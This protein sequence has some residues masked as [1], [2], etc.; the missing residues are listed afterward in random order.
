MFSWKHIVFVEAFLG[1]AKQQS[2]PNNKSN[3]H[4]LAANKRKV[5]ARSQGRKSVQNHTFAKILFRTRSNIPFSRICILETKEQFNPNNT[6]KTYTNWR[7]TNARST[8]ENE[9]RYPNW[10]M[11]TKM[12]LTVNEEKVS[13]KWWPNRLRI[14]FPAWGLSEW[15]LCP[16]NIPVQ[17]SRRRV[18]PRKQGSE[19]RS[20][21]K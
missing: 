4:K 17:R 6:S 19:L 13:N 7:L 20:W 14:T 18:L 8:Q 5:N 16:S 12:F 10:N 2:N 1:E 15:E 11:K 9:I 21:T 3:V